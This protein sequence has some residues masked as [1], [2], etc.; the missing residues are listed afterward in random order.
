GIVDQLG[1]N[2]TRSPASSGV[3]QD[4]M[5]DAKLQFD[6]AILKLWTSRHHATEARNN[7]CE[8]RKS[9]ADRRTQDTVDLRGRVHLIDYVMKRSL[10]FVAGGFRRNRRGEGDCSCVF[11]SNAMKKFG[12]WKQAVIRGPLPDGA[13]SV[14]Q[15]L[16]RTRRLRCL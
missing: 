3:D 15:I 8:V 11:V 14:T 10:G 6:S 9:F 16:L 7:F 5:F 12:H 2:Q 4:R 13:R 1:D